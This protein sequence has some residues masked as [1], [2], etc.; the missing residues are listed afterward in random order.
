MARILIVEDE[1]GALNSLATLL[2]EEGYEALKAGD[3][4]RGLMKA[5]TEEPD[6][7]LLDIRLPK[8]DGLTV[9][10]RMRQGHNDAAV[11]IMTADTTSSNAIKATQYGAFDYITKPINF[12]HL[13]ILVKRALEYRDLEREVRKLRSSQ[14]D[15]NA[16]PAM[17]GHSPAMQ[18]VYKLIGRVA[19][20]DATVC[21]AGESGT[22][23][24]LVVNAI[25]EYSPRA[26]GPLV[27]VNCAAIPEAL[28]EAELFGH[29]RGAF[30]HAVSRRIGRFEQANGGTLFLDEIAELP[31]PLQAKL[32]RAIQE[33][34][35]E[36]LGSNQPIQTN[37]RLVVAT[38]QDLD[39]AV[40]TGQFREDLF[41]RLSVVKIC[42][43]PLRE[44]REDIPLLV[45]RFL[46][47]SEKPVTI[48]QDALDRIIAHSWP[49]N[50]RE[51]EN[52]VARAIAIAPGGVITTE[53][54]EFPRR[55]APAGAGWLGQIPYRE[56][57]KAV[58]RMV[59][60][61][62]LRAALADVEGN[63]LKAAALLGI[64]RR[65][66]YEKMRDH[67]MR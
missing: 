17:V 64:Q 18:Q 63:K 39:E 47:R 51:L 28:L 40:A 11:L 12:D 65:L 38:A 61:E 2:N 55:T 9:L 34:T 5:L 33:R 16:Y 6:L 37:F 48:Q 60:A 3:G 35:I 53:C 44:R 14:A 10:Q 45:Q 66:L 36:R 8:M 15:D 21:V 50:V 32:L 13:L 25:H 19:S 26:H 57:F 62:L 42:L 43:P 4:E 30:T 54:V 52:V 41:Y 23:K 7:V 49:G 27:K 20:S 31:L 46:G 1:C 29:E 67:G 58:I 22:G 56:G 59:E 24:E